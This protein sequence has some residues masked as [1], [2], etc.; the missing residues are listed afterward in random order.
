MNIERTSAI[1]T[2]SGG[3]QEQKERVLESFK[4]MFLQKGLRREEREKTPEEREIIEA[5]IEKLLVFLNEYDVRPLSLGVHHIHMIDKEKLSEKELEEVE[6]MFP[7][8]T[9]FYLVEPQGVVMLTWKLLSPLEFAGIIAHELIHF[10]SH[11]AVIIATDTE[12]GFVV[13]RIGLAVQNSREGFPEKGLGYFND[14]NEAVAEELNKRFYSTYLGEISL[15]AEEHRS[16]RVFTDAEVVGV[17]VEEAITPDGMRGYVA[18]TR[19][20]GYKE[21]RERLN[22]IITTIFENKKSYFSDREEVFKIFAR[23]AMTGDVKE[24]ALLVEEVFGR[25]AFKKLASS[26]EIDQEQEGE[27]KE[28]KL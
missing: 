13:H 28:K 5:V 19:N 11:N 3:K 20:R 15:L 9:G 25:G 10:L 4:E 16:L 26:L 1:S 2:V 17:C 23:S 27:Q 18:K 7:T 12:E 21:A 6:K 24:L 14:L 22:T 8:N